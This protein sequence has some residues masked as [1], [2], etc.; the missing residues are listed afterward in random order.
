MVGRG[1]VTAVDGGMVV[2][3]HVVGSRKGVADVGN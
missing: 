3:V 1:M 2:I